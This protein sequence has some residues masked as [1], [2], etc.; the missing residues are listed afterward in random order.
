[1][2]KNKPRRHRRGGRRRKAR[3]SIHGSRG[4][5]RPFWVKGTVMDGISSSAFYTQARV[6]SA[7]DYNPIEEEGILSDGD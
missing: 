7:R 6:G 5:C 2:R 3:R 1:M 4:R